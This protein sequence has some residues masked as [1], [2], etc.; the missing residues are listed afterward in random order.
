MVRF[1]DV[2]NTHTNI[3]LSLLNPHS[4]RLTGFGHV[5]HSSQYDQLPLSA[6]MI[7][8]G[9]VRTW[10]TGACWIRVV[11]RPCVILKGFIIY[12]VDE[13]NLKYFTYISFFYTNE[14]MCTYNRIFTLL[15][16]TDSVSSF[17]PIELLYTG[18]LHNVYFMRQVA[19][20]APPVSMNVNFSPFI[21]NI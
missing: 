4:S 15:N 6:S 14:P 3:L 19:L 12:Q 13:K 20:A 8:L 5:I 11:S 1:C 2:L 7:V 10:N 18:Y 16:A 21:D 9:S 17:Y